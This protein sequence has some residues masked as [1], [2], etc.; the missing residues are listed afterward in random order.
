MRGTSGISLASLAIVPL[1]TFASLFQPGAS[2]AQKPS[3]ITQ[4][5]I[6]S[7][8][9]WK[10]VLGPVAVPAPWNVAVCPGTTP[11]LC[12]RYQGK[13][14]GTVEMGTHPLESR[15]EFRKMLKQAGLASNPVNLQNSKNRDRV[16]IALKNW[17]GNYYTFFKQDSKTEYGNQTRF[18]TQAPQVLQVG[19][20]T[21]VSYGFAAVKPE[22]GVQEQRLGY[23]AFDGRILYVI[24]TAFD[25]DAGRGSFGKLEDLQRFEPY[26]KSVVA[27]LQLP[28]SKR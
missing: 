22:G 23:V 3:A 27:H 14:V 5:S 9:V 17:V 15:A 20:L 16:I 18:A 7:S 11:L 21:G 8:N 26:L 25:P 2:L 6:R 10:R 28:I 1:M 24:T 12:V 13:L 19:N 4:P